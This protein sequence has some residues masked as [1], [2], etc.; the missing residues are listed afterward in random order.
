MLK[1]AFAIALLGALVGAAIVGLVLLLWSGLD[2][3][4]WVYFLMI[5]WFAVGG[6]VLG[7]FA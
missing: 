3:K 6:A 1:R 4:G 5:A 7:G 2:D